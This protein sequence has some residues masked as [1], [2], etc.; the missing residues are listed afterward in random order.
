MEKK[1]Y[2]Q[3]QEIIYT[4]TLDNGLKV[5]LLP[6]ND[7]HK[8]YGLFSTNFGSIDNQF[9][10]NGKTEMVTAPDGIAHF[11]EHKLFEKE[12]GD[13]F[14]KFGRL[15]ASANAFTSFTRTAYLFSSTSHVSES[16]TTLLDFVQEPYFTEET[17]NKEK[18]IIAQEIQMYE[19][20]P[21]WRLFFGILGNMYP[22]HP[23]HIDIAGTVDSIM[24]ITPEL[25]YENHATFYH[26]SN[27]NLFVV[28]KL[29]PEE[30][31]KLI[32][33]NQAQ[34]EYAPAEAIKRIFPEETIKDIKPYNFINMTV[35]RP[36]SIVGV[37]GIK[38]I[39]SG[40]E[41]LKY[42]TT[43]DLLLTLLFGPTSANYL[44]LYDKGVI[45]DSF[46]FEFNLDRTFHF[47]DVSGDTKDSAVF[48][49]EIKKL[50]LEAKMSSEFTDENLAIVKKRT[51]GQELQSLNS[52]EYIANQY[53]QPI[54]GE[55]T[56]FDV[57]PIIES[58]TLDEIKKVAEE[59]M[60]EDH[61][62]T[63]H[64]LPKGDKD[65]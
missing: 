12:D 21:D 8:T 42:K 52:L 16:L 33:E 22:K 28:G 29:D 43:M 61:M 55:A 44:K 15:G 9:V 58:I 56:L 64:I 23:L 60:I 20:E 46:S 6:K 40:I 54:Y 50:L 45:D 5:T 24:D 25:L 36:K 62:T 63:F 2:E 4:E 10:P 59:F 13:V 3:L 14:N 48:S 7:F 1:V 18:G 51:I 32:R 31:M 19:D 17:V 35:N 57:V 11:L 34:K 26:P 65:A 53:S 37:K 47:I 41:A 39:P 38:E 27:M 30:M 49:A